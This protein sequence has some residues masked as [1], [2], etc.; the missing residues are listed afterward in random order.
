M[1]IVIKIDRRIFSDECISKV[2]YWF[3][4]RYT[5]IRNL[6]NDNTEQIQLCPRGDIEFDEKQ[7]EHLFYQ[8]LNDF[9]LRQ[10][11]EN[12]THDIRTILYAKA[13]EKYID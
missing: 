1:A 4:D 6:E 11:V 12:E 5:I 9:K 13:F 10:I 8:R 7:V 3:S 2:V